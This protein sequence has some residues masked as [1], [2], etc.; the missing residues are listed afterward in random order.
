MCMGVGISITLA[1]CIPDIF[2]VESKLMISF[3]SLYNTSDR[4][5]L[6]I[7]RAPKYLIIGGKYEPTLE[8]RG[9]R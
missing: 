3:F 9:F 8:T 7:I 6:P 4:F 1:Q 5:I 2:W